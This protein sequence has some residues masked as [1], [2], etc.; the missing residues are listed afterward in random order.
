MPDIRRVVC[1]RRRLQAN[2]LAYSV[3]RPARSRSAPRSHQRR[4]RSR[5]W[6]SAEVDRPNC[7]I[8]D[9]HRV[10]SR[11][12]ERQA[13]SV[14]ISSAAIS[15]DCV[16]APTARS[17]DT[18]ASM[19]PL[20]GCGRRRELTN[21]KFGLLRARMNTCAHASARPAM[22]ITSSRRQF[23][24]LN[25]AIR[26]LRLA[27]L[28]NS[29]RWRIPPGREATPDCRPGLV[30]STQSRLPADSRSQRPRIPAGLIEREQ[31]QDGA[32]RLFTTPSAIRRASAMSTR[33]TIE[34]GILQ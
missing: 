10:A 33:F 30:A 15:L 29:Y 23:D 19:A 4:S 18:S 6:L 1:R 14:P 11:R 13:D 25:N 22:A 12:R 24:K 7:R 9:G 2:W 32:C 34:R 16:Q 5:I 8:K 26:R 17:V 21:R 20:T 27:L 28:R 3:A 31:S